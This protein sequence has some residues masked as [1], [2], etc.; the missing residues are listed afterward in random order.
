MFCFVLFFHFDDGVKKG[1][2]VLPR[3]QIHTPTP[4]LV[5]TAVFALRN[6]ALCSLALC[7]SGAEAGRRDLFRPSWAGG[8]AGWDHMAR[9][10]RRV[11]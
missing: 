2:P 1:T 6:R 8:P 9:V 5:G 7:P 3:F 11:T 4:W 10:W